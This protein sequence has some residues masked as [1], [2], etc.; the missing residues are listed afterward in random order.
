MNTFLNDMKHELRKIFYPFTESN[1]RRY[2]VV[3]LITHFV[4]GQAYDL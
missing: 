4:Q 3:L 2:L 1:L